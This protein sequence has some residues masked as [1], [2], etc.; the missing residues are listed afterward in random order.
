MTAKGGGGDGDLFFTESG[1]GGKRHEERFV[2]RWCLTPQEREVRFLGKREVECARSSGTGWAFF[3]LY[4]G[5]GGEEV[6]KARFLSPLL[7]KAG[8]MGWWSAVN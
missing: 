4:W 6:K 8:E 1:R 3:F 2:P 7:Q 5:G